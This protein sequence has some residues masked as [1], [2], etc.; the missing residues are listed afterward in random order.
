MS[1]E[2]FVNDFEAKPETVRTLPLA[3]LDCVKGPFIIVILPR[4]FLIIFRYSQP[5]LI[6]QSIKYVTVPSEGANPSYGYW[7]VVSALTIYTGLA[8]SFQTTLTSKWLS[9]RT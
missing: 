7:L 6:K 1:L 9:K 2:Y 4:L 8:V 3:L 5:S